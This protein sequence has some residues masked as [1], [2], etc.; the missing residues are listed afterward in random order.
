VISLLPIGKC[1]RELL[2]HISGN[3]NVFNMPVKILPRVPL[4]P[5]S[6]NKKRRQYRAR[7]FLALAGRYQGDR[8]LGITEE[9]LY[10]RELNFVFGLARKS[11]KCAVIS[12]ARLGFG[13]EEKLYERSLKEA[14]HELGHTMGL[15]HCSHRL[16][17]MHFSNTLLD[18]DEKTAD[19]CHTC[20][21]K[22]KGPNF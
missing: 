21:K 12:V 4:P 18:T 10:V 11:G 6:Y 9:D 3:L 17:V 7:K 14:V 15:D 2:Q 16:C 13:D 19:F 22:L 8:V 1:G 5:D 20:G